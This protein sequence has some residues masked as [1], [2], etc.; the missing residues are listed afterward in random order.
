MENQDFD[1][2]REWKDDILED[3]CAFAN[4]DG[5]SLYVGK[6]NKGQ[7]FP[8]KNIG[9]LLEDIPSKI[10]HLLGIVASVEAVTE[11]KETFIRIKMRSYPNPISYRGRYYV[12]SGSTT[13]ELTGHPLDEF[14]LR[15]Q[16]KNWDDF[17]IPNVKVEDLSAE[18]F[19]IFRKK[20]LESERLS[21][22]DL[23]L[24]DTELL[25]KLRLIEN[26][27]LTRA[28]VM[29]FHEDP[30]KWVIGS[31]VKVGYFDDDLI[32][33]DEIYGPL[34]SLPDKV[35]NLVFTKYLKGLISYD[36]INRVET[37]P[38]PRAAF[39]ELLH[40][41]I[42]H[43]LYSLGS[44]IQIRVYPDKIIIGNVAKLPLNWTV[45]NLYETHVSI[46]Y[47]PSIAKTFF[48][49][50]FVEAWGRGVMRINESLEK[51]GN[52]PIEYQ[53]SGSDI[54]ATLK[55]HP[56][57]V[58]YNKKGGIKND[59]DHTINH[60]I[61]HTIKLGDIEQEVLD[62]IKGDPTLT[63]KDIKLKLGGN[64]TSASNAVRSLREKGVIEHS[65]SKKSGHWEI[66][67]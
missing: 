38:V 5:G 50:G 33:H 31:F 7:F 49:A 57:H 34:I 30:E 37:Y 40:N 27:C 26:G 20:A 59:M 55:V 41:A 58:E 60:T 3:I 28:A 10:R 65:G 54:M 9:K 21:E 15:K 42:Q 53:Y 39:R 45:E 63:I 48:R 62:I 11:N 46:P 6:D 18:A 43:K 19:K 12:R 52:P 17:P 1:W 44:P 67:I 24:S 51:A 25:E 29:L 36:G 2:K 13:V 56:M 16:G 32:Y 22:D 66:L 47:N 14:I 64:P 4:T 8:L 35:V 61:N 23:N